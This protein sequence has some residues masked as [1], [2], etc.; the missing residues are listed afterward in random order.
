[1]EV[2]NNKYYVNGVKDGKHVWRFAALQDEV[3]KKLLKNKSPTLID[4][5]MCCQII[6]ITMVFREETVNEVYERWCRN[7]NSWETFDVS[8]HYLGVL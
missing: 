8:G 7:S 4:G 1:M 6:D 3:V 2:C 5:V